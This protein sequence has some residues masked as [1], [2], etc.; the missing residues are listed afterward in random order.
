MSKFLTTHPS[1][2]PAA[3]PRF[4]PRINQALAN[5]PC[6]LGVDGGGTKTH[7]VITTSADQIIGEGFSGASNPVRVGFEKAVAHINKAVKQACAQAGITPH[8]ITAG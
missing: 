6:F 8:D 1:Q 2:G 7:A 3:T 5:A 4:A